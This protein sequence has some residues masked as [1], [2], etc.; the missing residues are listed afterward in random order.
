MGVAG[1]SGPALMPPSRLCDTGQ[2]TNFFKLAFHSGWENRT[3]H[4]LRSLLSLLPGI[5]PLS[6][7]SFVVV[8]YRFLI[9]SFVLFFCLIFVF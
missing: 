4:S 1:S 6:I 7:R 2:V 5:F 9:F 3:R 8:L